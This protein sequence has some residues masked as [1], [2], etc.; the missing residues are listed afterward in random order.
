MDTISLRNTKFEIV[1]NSNKKM[2]DDK[3]TFEF[4]PITLSG[5]NSNPF[6]LL[7]E[8]DEDEEYR[9]NNNSHKVINNTEQ[10]RKTRKS[11]KKSSI[12]QIPYTAV[13]NLTELPSDIILHIFEYLFPFF[14]VITNL[15]SASSEAITDTTKLECILYIS[16]T[17]KKSIKVSK[18]W[19]PHCVTLET[20]EV[21]DGV[22]LRFFD[23]LLVNKNLFYRVFVTECENFLT[24][25]MFWDLLLEL[26]NQNEKLVHESSD[27]IHEV[28]RMV[29]EQ[30]H[31]S[32]YFCQMYLPKIFKYGDVE[33]V[34]FHGTE[35]EWRSFYI[36]FCRLLKRFTNMT[37]NMEYVQKLNSA[38]VE[39]L[40]GFMEH[41]LKRMKRKLL[42]TKTSNTPN[43]KQG[44]DKVQ[45]RIEQL[46][47]FLYVKMRTP[48][49]WEN[50]ANNSASFIY[51]SIAMIQE[52]QR[53]ETSIGLNFFKEPSKQRTLLAAI[54]LLSEYLLTGL[55]F[56]NRF[57]LLD[58]ILEV[59]EDSTDLDCVVS[60]KDVRNPIPY[61]ISTF[62]GNFILINSRSDKVELVDKF[63]NM[64]H[65]ICKIY[66]NNS[67]LSGSHFHTI[68]IELISSACERLAEFEDDLPMVDFVFKTFT[69]C[70]VAFMSSCS[71][72]VAQSLIP[73]T[74]WK[75]HFHILHVAL[76]NVNVF[77]YLLSS[78]IREL[79][80]AY[81]QLLYKDCCVE[82]PNYTDLELLVP[83]LLPSII[84][85]LFDRALKISINRNRNKI[86]RR[87]VKD[88]KRH[89]LKE[90]KNPNEKMIARLEM[91]RSYYGKDTRDM[92]N[93][94]SYLKT[95]LSIML[96]A[97]KTNECNILF[98]K[99]VN[100]LESWGMDR[101]GEI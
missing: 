16:K 50:G 45:T 29:F 46:F 2:P 77:K 54:F 53:D 24:V 40:T 17:F 47:T 12:T 34:V 28:I 39:S 21:V 58:E 56:S 97:E 32:D 18:Y 95:T 76:E 9:V 11:K 70:F 69:K 6:L 73:Q 5:S 65:R 75:S 44:L 25:S 38:V 89:S 94:H 60:S 68:H 91:L 92:I 79:N 1:I 86:T 55:F 87:S 88:N 15:T 36:K 30:V 61:L 101:V 90:R 80:D 10:K 72:S 85:T 8:L 99:F 82:I 51:S 35:E 14:N 71:V 48:I 63:C 66:D 27:D 93:N 62:F 3:P 23:Y 59:V 96:N 19:I 100:L 78:D 37:Q 33:N 4:S 42:N 13:S 52:S 41:E 98:N 22:I 57:S 74:V 83:N 64:V 7:D 67:M 43:A 31:H 49:L 20:R 84:R 81:K 26:L